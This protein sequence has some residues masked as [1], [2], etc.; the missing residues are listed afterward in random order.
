MTRADNRDSAL[1]GVRTEPGLDTPGF[2][3][4]YQEWL[5]IEGMF[6]DKFRVS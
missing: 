1:H 3:L 2:L 6:L 4:Q 5:K